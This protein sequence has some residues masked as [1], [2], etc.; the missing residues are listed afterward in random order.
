MLNL[1]IGAF[2]RGINVGGNNL[3]KMEEL[4]KV[5]KSMGFKMLKPY[6]PAGT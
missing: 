3:I 5:L 4:K 1:A 6:L 2:L